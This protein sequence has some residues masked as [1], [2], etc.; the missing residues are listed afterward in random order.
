MK[1][2]EKARQ[3]LE[4][5]KKKREFTR[6]KLAED[7]YAVKECEAAVAEAE[8]AEY[9][10]ELRAWGLTVDEL[11]ALRK[12]LESKSLAEVLKQKEAEQSDDE[13]IEVEE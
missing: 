10:A 6:K 11:K 12:A 5:A 9:V 7:D 13:L 1:A 8:N 2:L 3:D 4:K